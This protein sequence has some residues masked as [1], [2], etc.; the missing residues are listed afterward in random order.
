MNKTA[1][2]QATIQSTTTEPIIFTTGYASRIARGLADRP[3]HFYMTGSMGLAGDIGAG[4]AHT[5]R[6]PVVVVDGDGGLAMNP[7]CLLTIGA[8]PGALHLIH[9]ALD[10][11]VYDST[12]GQAV[13]TRASSLE[14]LARAAG[15]PQVS[16]ANT[17][18]Q[19]RQAV[20]AALR[21]P[22]P[23]FVH[24]PLTPTSASLPPRITQPLPE[25]ARRLTAHVTRMAPRPVLEG[26]AWPHQ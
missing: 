18:D 21:R 17:V 26:S 1:A 5:S 14:A 2:I 23:A 13:P 9:V 3:N 20:T 24:C 8:W 22:E 16:A 11:G 10:D 25:I 15:Y 7:G 12:G 6:L 19:L 4:L